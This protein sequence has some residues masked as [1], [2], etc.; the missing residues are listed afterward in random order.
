[1]TERVEPEPS[2]LETQVRRVAWLIA[3]VAVVAG[4]AFLPIGW[5]AAGLPIHDALS[6][7]IGLI[8]ANVPEGLL[9]TITLALA[10]GV[11]GLARRGALVKRLSAVE[12]LGSTTVICTDKTGTLTENR[13]RAVSIWTPL[14]ELDL[15]G[16]A[17]I[18]AAVAGNP[19]LGLLARATASCSTADVDPAHVGKS[20]GE[21]TEIGLL[22]AVRSLGIDVATRRRES[23]RRSSTAST[24]PCASC[25]PSTSARTARSQSTRKEHRR[26][27]SRGRQGSARTT[28]TGSSMSRT[29][30][31]YLPC[32][33]ATRAG[34]CACSPSRGGDCP[35]GAAPPARREDAERELC[36]LGLV[37]LFDPPRPEVAAAV[38]SC[39]RAGIRIIVVTGDYG[40]TA[41]EIARRVGISR[42]GT[43]VRSPASSSSN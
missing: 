14:G 24:R 18:V 41:A 21:A 22:E 20:R 43:P 9:P 26:R 39:H 19:V 38:A 12:T 15:E 35:D 3:I 5:L 28:T 32:S 6:F 37:A 23:R 33:S 29:A 2:P 42:D 25:P 34:G 11:A 30:P 40:L 36:L 10:V 8:V 27:S 17:D 1:M 16:E 7:A 13:M 31:R 4:L